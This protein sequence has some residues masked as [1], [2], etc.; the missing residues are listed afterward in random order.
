MFE[1]DTV[2]RSNHRIRKRCMEVC[3]GV[4][5]GSVHGAMIVERPHHGVLVRCCLA[6][7]YHYAVAAVRL[8]SHYA[9]A[10]VPVG[11]LDT[12]GVLGNWPQNS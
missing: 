3:K 6:S 11:T 9:A 1:Q 2:D 10:A 7:M 5:V 4:G 8:V 12:V